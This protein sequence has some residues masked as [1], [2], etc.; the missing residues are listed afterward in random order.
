FN[1]LKYLPNIRDQ[2]FPQE[3]KKQYNDDQVFV[4]DNCVEELW[5]P[6]TNYQIKEG[7]RSDE[8]W[9]R[10][11]TYLHQFYQSNNQ[12]QTDKYELEIQNHNGSYE[13]DTFYGYVLYYLVHEYA[14]TKH[15][16]AYVH[17]AQHVTNQLYGLKTFTGFGVKEFISVSTIRKCCY[18]LS[19][20]NQIINGIES[21]THYWIAKDPDVG[22]TRATVL[23]NYD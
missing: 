19:E 11:I 18:P 7:K 13:L 12:F 6:A 9:D 16:L 1:H 17:N 10:E 14:E 8:K 23:L 4:L 2:I 21:I 3:E 15:M 22:I 20:L 5:H